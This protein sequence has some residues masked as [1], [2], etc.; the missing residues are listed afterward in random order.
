MELKDHIVRMTLGPMYKAGSGPSTLELRQDQRFKAIVS[1]KRRQC[2]NRNGDI[3]RNGVDGFEDREMAHIWE[4]MQE[5][6]EVRESKAINSSLE[7]LLET[8]TD[9]A[10]L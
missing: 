9:D 10:M 1:C 3:L 4:R 7:P 2:D 5:M 8:M 6:L